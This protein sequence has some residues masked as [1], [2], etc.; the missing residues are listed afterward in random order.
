MLKAT[1][2]ILILGI[3]PFVFAPALSIKPAVSKKV[4]IKNIGGRFQLNYHGKPY[5]IKGAGGYTYFEQLK[6]YGG[7]S[8][9]LWSTDNAREY[10][11]KAQ[12]LGLT[13]TLGLY[14]ELERHGFNYDD[15]IAVA[16]QLEKLKK[17]VLKFK[18][19]PALLMWGVGNEVDQ[20]AKNYNVWN[21]VNDLARF[22]HEVDPDHPTT[23]MLAGVPKKHV[24]EIVKRCP[25][26]DV[27]SI[28]AFKDLPYIRHK[29]FDAGWDG[30]YLVGEWGASGY[31]ETPKTPWGAFIEETSTE[32]AMVCEERYKTAIANNTDRCIGSYIFYWGYKQA[33]THTLLSLFL[34]SG[35][36]T[37]IIDVLQKN[38]NST[39][40]SNKPSNKAPVI[41]PIGI[42]DEK[43]HLGV[44]LKP[45]TLHMAYTDCTDPE[46]DP[47]TYK[48]EI[49]HEST[50]KKEGGDTED[51]PASINGLIID[52]TGRALSFKAPEQKGPYRLF[53]S[54]FDGKNNVATAN[55]PFYVK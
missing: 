23:T 34:E 38:W 18:D 13:V 43:I 55:A 29:I 25:D 12:E 33:R 49:Y 42:D 26:I 24:R 41:L 17:E 14:M 39:N 50:E 2:T 11:D 19:H 46:N 54:V 6:Q 15:K 16:K 5:F 52:G 3:L 32:K 47:L 21:A 40:P 7:N 36:E 44:F 9:R 37:A 8:I 27:L 28:N 10:L 4:E 30:P 48:W 45:G 51:K 53:V 35:E 22:I 1:I 31:W 20:F